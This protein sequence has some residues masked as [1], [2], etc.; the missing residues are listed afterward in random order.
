MQILFLNYITLGPIKRCKDRLEENQGHSG[1]YDVS[2][3]ENTYKSD[4]KVYCFN[5]KQGHSS[6]H[7]SHN[8]ESNELVDD[9]D[10]A[11]RFEVTYE[12]A[13]IQDIIMMVDAAQNCSQE[14]FYDD[15]QR[16]HLLVNKNFL[17]GRNAD[18][19]DLLK[20]NDCICPDFGKCQGSN[21]PISLKGLINNKD[22]LPLT[23]IGVGD[24]GDSNEHTNFRIGKLVCKEQN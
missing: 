18:A 20:T 7:F 1:V 24:T 14:I 8:R 12:T 4:I 23:A 6:F 2:N 17:H 15:C 21:T 9:D 5:D 19:S 16:V 13:S 10:N 3:L 22:E 11:K